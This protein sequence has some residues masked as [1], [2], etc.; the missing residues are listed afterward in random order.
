MDGNHVNFKN[1]EDPSELSGKI[2]EC[3][4][5]SEEQVW[6]CMRVRVDKSTPNDINTYRKVMRSIK[7]NITEEVPLEDIGEIVRLPMYVC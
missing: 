4:W 3:S 5:D 2:I 7:D 1:G 6:N